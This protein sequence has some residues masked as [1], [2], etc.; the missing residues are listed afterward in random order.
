MQ[1]KRPSRPEV[2]RPGGGG[3]DGFD[4]SRIPFK[5]IVAAIIAVLAILWIIRGGPIY[6]VAPD[7]EGVVLTFGDYSTTTGP[8]LHF[9][10]PWPVQTVF[11][12]KVDEMKRLEF[13]YRSADAGRTMERTFRTSRD[14]LGEAQMLTGDEN[15]VDVSMVLQYR[16]TDGREYLFNYGSPADVDNTLRDLGESVLR[17]VVGDHPIDDVLTTGRFEIQAEI[18]AEL[19]E[20]A[21]TYRLGVGEFNCQLQDVL[22]PEPVEDSF[23]DVATAREDREKTINTA[24]AFQ[25]ELIP[26]A[27]GEAAR[28]R[29]EA[30][31]YRDARIAEATGRVA[32]FEAI[33]QRYR[34]AP[35]VTRTRLYLEAMSELLPKLR[36]TIIDEEAGIV[37]L[38]SLDRPGGMPTLPG[39]GAEPRQDEGGQRP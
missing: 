16:I 23:A 29:E 39:A 11:T 12:P 33:A 2:V 8:G 3:G 31:G 36:M 34:Q 32:R 13:G 5:A 27:E 28:V 37:N 9:K 19:R 14:L 1:S 20:L 10:W 15:V 35:E 30:E 18:E 17:Q 21:E 24:R 4:L 26:Q 7:E 25:R 22:P 6:T 38:K